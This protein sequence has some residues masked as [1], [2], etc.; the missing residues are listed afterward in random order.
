MQCN[1]MPRRDIMLMM[2]VKIWECKLCNNTANKFAFLPK[3]K[4]VHR[5][6]NAT[7][8]L[9]HILCFSILNTQKKMFQPYIYTCTYH[10][11]LYVCMLYVVV[12]RKVYYI[13]KMK[14]RK[15]VNGRGEKNRYRSDEKWFKWQL[16]SLPWSAYFLIPTKTAITKQ[17]SKLHVTVFLLFVN[18]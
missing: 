10:T 16:R 7:L 18:F 13:Q 17:T 9:L 4:R 12:I 14:E 5:T 15:K 11:Y 3:R 8:H 6:R 1:A 2:R